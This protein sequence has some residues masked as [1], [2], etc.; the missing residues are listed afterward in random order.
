VS[1][2]GVI[3]IRANRPHV[4]FEGYRKGSRL[5]APFDADGWF[6]TGDLGRV[7]QQGNLVFIERKA[8][9]I[10]V[11]GEFVPI[12]FVEDHFAKLDGV[13]DVAVWHRDSELVDQEVS[14]YVVADKLDRAALVGAGELLP[15][16][17]RPTVVVR[18]D[19]IPRDAGVGKIRRRQ[20]HEA[21][22]LEVLE[23]GVGR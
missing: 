2:D 10:R 13:D 20:L 7:D 8:E 15:S 6:D 9:S 4:L 23:L 12:G 3:E 17:M 14:L 19:A 16:F 1:T 5:V 21:T 22:V 18:V 11:K